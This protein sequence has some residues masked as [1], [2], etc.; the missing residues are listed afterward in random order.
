VNQC[1]FNIE[2]LDLHNEILNEQLKYLDGQERIAADNDCHL[3]HFDIEDY[4]AESTNLVCDCLNLIPSNQPSPRAL[5]ERAGKGLSRAAVKIAERG[6]K[7]PLL[8]YGRGAFNSMDRRILG[9]ERGDDRG[10][11]RRR[12]KE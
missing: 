10:R 8:Y 1:V 4:S 6:G 7:V 9:K 12:R 3:V 11:R 5:V 2:Q